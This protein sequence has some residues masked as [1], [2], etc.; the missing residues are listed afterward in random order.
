MKDE[1]T[2]LLFIEEGST[3][4]MDAEVV[5]QSFA[6]M[7]PKIRV[8]T[9]HVKGGTSQRMKDL[10]VTHLP[11]IVLT[12]GEFSRIRYY[13]APLGYE[14]PP[15]A[16]AILELSVGTPRLAHMARESLSKTSHRMNIKVFVTTSC[17]FCATVARH[18]YRAAIGS[19]RAT[20]EVIDS[21]AFPELAARHSVIGVPKTVIN[22][23]L[24]STGI[25]DEV[26]F[27]DM[28]RDS[29]ASL[30]DGMYR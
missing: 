17:P 8:E 3:A 2:L 5:A 10:K 29:D 4:S 25:I 1:V 19:P 14:L 15:F 13:G 7:T 27:F 22:D 12:K 18:S 20:A 30:T 23:T 9:E 6:R 28:L 24:D 21:S 11:C 16:D 26:A